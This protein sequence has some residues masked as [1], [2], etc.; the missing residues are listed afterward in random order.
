M[1]WHF[2]GFCM[3][4][5]VPRRLVRFVNEVQDLIQ[6]IFIYRVPKLSQNYATAYQ[7]FVTSLVYHKIL[8]VYD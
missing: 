4:N 8:Y 7:K 3:E 5:A 1:E 6:L 2:N